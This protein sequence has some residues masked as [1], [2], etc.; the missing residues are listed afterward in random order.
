MSET[1]MKH[2]ARL[3]V[4]TGW[5]IFFCAYLALFTAFSSAGLGS[6][7]Q[8][9]FI[10]VAPAILLSFGALKLIESYVIER[11]YLFQVV[12]H[13]GLAVGFGMLWYIGIQ[14]GYGL[15]DGWATG[16]IVG[17]PLSGIALSW[18]AMQG[19][20][21][22]AAILGFA[23]AV[24]N[25]IALAKAQIDIEH[26]RDRHVSEGSRDTPHPPLK[27]VMVKDG[28]ALKPIAIKDI[29]IVS[30]AGDYTEVKTKN[31]THFSSTSLNQFETELPTQEF[32]RVHRSHIVRMDA[33][34]SVE[35]AGNG[36]LTLHLPAGMSVNTSRAGAKRVRDT[37]L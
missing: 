13:L 14:V 25:Q 17:R 2:Q 19:I 9:A 21:L 11:S 15:Q 37:A 32:S 27:Q 22:Y 29:L 23:Y 34:L 28:N 12:A 10:N 26:L 18:Q 16:G 33:V 6:A 36:K 3:I 20:T 5:G 35:S 30:G 24:R 7:L 1:D 8:R 31:G 4:L